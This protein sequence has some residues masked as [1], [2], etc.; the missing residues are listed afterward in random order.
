MAFPEFSPLPSSDVGE[1][2]Q[3][4]AP[5]HERRRR[6]APAVPAPPADAPTA[7]ADALR[8]ARSY[9]PEVRE[10]LRAESDEAAA[11]A[12]LELR[13]PPL[14]DHDPTAHKA[15]ANAYRTGEKKQP[16]PGSAASLLL[17]VVLFLAVA[18]G[19]LA[20][21]ITAWGALALPDRPLLAPERFGMIPALEIVLLAP[22]ALVPLYLVFHA[23]VHWRARTHGRGM[24]RVALRDDA[25]RSR[26]LPLRSPFHGICSSWG[27]LAKCLEYALYGFF[28]L[29]VL[30]WWDG[31]DSAAPSAAWVVLA[32]AVPVVVVLVLVTSRVKV[33]ERRNALLAAQLYRAADDAGTREVRVR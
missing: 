19:V 33:W 7:A 20:A 14:G 12:L 10:L 5:R 26:G 28:A 15:R 25:A 23:S 17:C 2:A 1:G 30:A 32:Y 27:L 16:A 6:R 13:I 24:L 21:L 3:E 11:A 4:A 29:A 22:T 31:R 8:F 9:R 18:A